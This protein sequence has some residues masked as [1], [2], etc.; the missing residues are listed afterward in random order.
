MS[1]FR[2]LVCVDGSRA[3]LAAARLAIRMVADHGGTLRAVSVVEEATARGGPRPPTDGPGG[4]HDQLAD[5]RAILD[6]VATIGAGQGA[7]V[8]THLLRGDPLREILRD[9]RTWEPD[10]VVVGRTG[11][12]GPV[13]PLVGSLAM[14][15]VEF[16]DWPVVVVPAGP[17][18]RR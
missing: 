8:D 7:A 16:S 9:A 12:R 2:L 13:S 14:H 4:V 6:R 3:A 10:L 18:Q 11:R 5:V 17:S 1:G 15:L